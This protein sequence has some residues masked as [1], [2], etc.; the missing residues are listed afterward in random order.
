MNNQTT[1]LDSAR[2]ENKRSSRQLVKRTPVSFVR[3]EIHKNGCKSIV[4]RFDLILSVCRLESVYATIDARCLT[5]T[6]A[7]L[8]SESVPKR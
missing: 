1:V 3:Q 2:T 7:E 5:M 8:A 6:H 4:A